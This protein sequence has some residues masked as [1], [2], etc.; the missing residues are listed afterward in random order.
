M[1]QS[2]AV[3]TQ[4]DPTEEVSNRIGS[5][6]SEFTLR[7]GAPEYNP[8]PFAFKAAVDG[9][10]V[11][12]VYGQVLWGRAEVQLLEVC[13][14]HRGSG[15]GK[16]ILSAVEEFAKAH[17]AIGVHLWTPTWQ[18]EGF[19]EKAGYTELGR[20]PLNTQGHFNGEQKFHII[21]H[22]ELVA[23]EPAD[24]EVQENARP[25]AGATRITV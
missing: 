12:E 20:L 18:G 4:I 11:A 13:E 1:A 6:L 22:K 2:N 8:L 14:E 7:E 17:N 9:K 5:A 19:Y 16:D 25:Y 10:T 3:I 23:S 21:Y 24:I 15:I